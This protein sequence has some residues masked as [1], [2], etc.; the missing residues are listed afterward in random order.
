M[1]LAALNE[2]SFVKVLASLIAS[3]ELEQ[4]FYPLNLSKTLAFA[5]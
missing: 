4:L 1:S 2:F 3:S 5:G